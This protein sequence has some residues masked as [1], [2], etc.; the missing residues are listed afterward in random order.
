[1]LFYMMYVHMYLFPLITYYFVNFGYF[2][3]LD[4]FLCVFTSS[5]LYYL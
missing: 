2:E 4:S 1:M 3:C 5:S